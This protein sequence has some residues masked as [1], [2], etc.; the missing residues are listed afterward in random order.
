MNFNDYIFS[1]PYS[2]WLFQGAV[3]TVIISILTTFISLFLGFFNSIL[4]I[5][6]NKA[7]RI[8]AKAYV[9]VFRNTPPVPL[10]LFLS[11]G[12]PGIYSSLTGK[13]F[14]RDTT[15]FFLILGISLNTSAYISEIIRSGLK[16][17]PNQNIH[18]A[19]I[20]GLNNK[21]INLSILLPQAIHNCLPALSTRI[22]HNIKNSSIALVL[23]LSVNHMEILGQS[24]RIAGQTFA[25][26]EPLIVSAIFYVTISI[27]LKLLINKYIEMSKRKF[28][29]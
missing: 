7:F 21:D 16:A 2:T 4:S 3:F 6:S 19:K 17:I 11:F 13:Q 18:S 26:S 14:F 1:T 22:I 23:P 25:W 8:Y 27:A 24:G 28:C 12:L 9:I 15:F 29:Y 10:L 20:L 5:S